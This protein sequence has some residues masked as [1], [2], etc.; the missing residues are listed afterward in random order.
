MDAISCKM[1]AKKYGCITCD[2]FT[3]RKSSI[4]KHLLSTKHQNRTKPNILEQESC[5][6]YICKNCD[7]KYKVRN[8]LWY[9]EQKCK[10][11]KKITSAIYC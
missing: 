6:E 7:K 4:D 2:Y 9:H 1:V 8:S 10:Y 5:P 11:K 3:S